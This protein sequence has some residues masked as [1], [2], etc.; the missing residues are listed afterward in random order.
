MEELQKGTVEV[1]LEFTKSMDARWNELREL[2][3]KVRSKDL[4]STKT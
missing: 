2:L 3:N 4:L 1:M